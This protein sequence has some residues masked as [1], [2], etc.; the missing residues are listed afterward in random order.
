M[1]TEL[2]PETLYSN[3]LTRLCAREDYI[4]EWNMP[5]NGADSSKIV[6]VASMMDDQ[7]DPV[8]SATEF[9]NLCQDGTVASLCSGI[10]LEK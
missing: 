6:E 10:V 1:G 2:V 5:W 4:E 3:E 7:K 8:S 9:W